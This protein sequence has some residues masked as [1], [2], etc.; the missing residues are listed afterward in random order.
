MMPSPDGELQLLARGSIIQ[1]Y[2]HQSVFGPLST[3][4]ASIATPFNPA[5]VLQIP[6]RP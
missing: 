6:R 5:W 2:E 4:I 1:D 3:S